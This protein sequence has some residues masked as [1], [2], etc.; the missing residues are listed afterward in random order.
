M[1]KKAFEDVVSKQPSVLW[2]EEVDYIAKNKNM[3]YSFLAALDGFESSQSLVIATSSKLN[4]VDKSL[5]RGGRLDLDVMFE[6]PTAE[7]RFAILKAHLQT[8]ECNAVNDE[9]LDIVAKASSGFVSS[10]LG[11]I[12]RNAHLLALKESRI[13]NA[14]STLTKIHLE[15]A[16]IQ[17]K[18][19]SI[20]DLLVEVPKTLW[21][22]IG[23]NE[24]IKFQ[25][26]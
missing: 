25:V 17:A 15:Q 6:M 21:S 5:R 1:L 26:R 2:I 4:D 8:I 7:D 18:P 20:S 10:D 14:E 22:E 13:Q 3:F 23:G 16:V 11:Q 12:V 24:T 9:E 19:L